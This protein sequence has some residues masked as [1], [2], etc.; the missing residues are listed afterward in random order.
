MPRTL[1]N[2]DVISGVV[3]DEEIT[4]FTIDIQTSMTYIVFDRKDV[5]GNIIIA[6][7]SHTLQ[8]AETAATIARASQ[9]AASN[10]GDVYAAIKQAM[11]EALPGNATIS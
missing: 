5:S 2:P 10:G 1:D 3:S 9:I 6:D 7:A 8:A 4:S 11:Y